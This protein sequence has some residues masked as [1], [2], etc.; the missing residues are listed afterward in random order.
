LVDRGIGAAATMSPKLRALLGIPVV[1]SAL[2]GA[3]TGAALGGTQAANEHPEDPAGAALSGAK[4]G[5]K[6]GGAFGALGSAARGTANLLRN[7]DIALLEKYGLEPSPIPGTPV[8]KQ[9]ETLSAFKNPP[10]GTNAASPST[11]Q[12]AALE[13]AEVIARDIADREGANDAQIGRLRQENQR[14]Y[15]AT[16]PPP[17]VRGVPEEIPP[18][19]EG[20]TV[21]IR[22]PES[23]SD[24]VYGKHPGV[25]VRPIIDA[26]DALRRR[27]DLPEATRGRLDE[28]GRR[29]REVSTPPE[30]VDEFDPNKVISPDGLTAGQMI[31]ML[32]K[33]AAKASGAQKAQLLAEIDRITAAA[34]SPVELPVAGA[35]ANPNDLQGIKRLAR[36]LGNQD[37]IQGVTAS[38]AALRSVADAA[39]EA[40]PEEIQAQD[41]AYHEA[42]SRTERAKESVGLT[43]KGTIPLE[44]EVQMSMEGGESEPGEDHVDFANPKTVETVGNHLARRGEDTKAGANATRRTQRLYDEGM[45]EVMEG[46]TPP[47]MIDV[48]S[49]MDRPRLQLAQENLQ[50]NPSHVFS[51]GG[52]TGAAGRA[53]KAGGRRFIYP[54]A[55]DLGNQDAGPPALVG[56]DIVEILR[57]RFK[58]KDE[59]VDEGEARE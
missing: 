18:E 9:G 27:A 25:P 41:R 32:Q 8:T 24:V 4:T 21:E 14:T 12:A 37:K 43:R 51:G 16:T 13:S 17:R 46:A 28:V 1:G 57:Q 22:A 2:Q 5:A 10:T 39:N 7:D 50:L 52:I 29:L 15:G 54:V 31:D 26:L 35:M 23:M 19:D 48:R 45:P 11:R 20:H 59:A 49:L 36:N 33:G 44:E 34:S 40:L 42:R 30:T 55:K 3:A 6:V 56:R 47:D 38:D 58:R 53:V